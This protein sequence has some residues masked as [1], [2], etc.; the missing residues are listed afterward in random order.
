ME[1]E[2]LILKG[3][4][5]IEDEDKLLWDQLER[6]RE[7]I[8][9]SIKA[10]RV[11]HHLRS[12]GVI[13][14][15]DEEE[16]T[17]GDLTLKNE[18]MR[19]SRLLDILQTKGKKAYEVFMT[20]LETQYQ[21]VYTK[22]SGNP[23]KAGQEFP[24]P[25]PLLEQHHMAEPFPRCLIAQLV[26]LESQLSSKQRELGH[27]RGKI[28]ALEDRLKILEAKGVELVQVQDRLQRVQEERDNYS[29]ELARVKDENYT[30]AMRMMT[31]SNERTAAHM[32][33]RELQLEVDELKHVCN[34]A[35][36][37]CEV[38]R[39]NSRRV[40]KD[41]ER[42]PHA[43]VLLQLQQENALLRN[44][45]GKEKGNNSNVSCEH[46][47]EREELLNQIFSLRQELARAEE[48]RDKYLEDKGCLELKCDTTEKDCQ[49]HKHRIASILAE[50]QDVEKEREKALESRDHAQGEHARCL[51]IKDRQRKQLR[52]LQ[53][54]LD[55]LRV[56]FAQSQAQINSLNACAK[57][58]QAKHSASGTAN[59]L[60]P[61]SGRGMTSTG[62]EPN[63]SHPHVINKS[64]SLQDNI[65][66]LSL[67]F[68]DEVGLCKSL[69]ASA[70]K[71]AFM[72][73]HQYASREDVTNCK[74]K[75]DVH[76][77]AA[78][79]FPLEGSPTETAPNK[80]EN[81]K[82][83]TVDCQHQQ[84]RPPRL[85][86]GKYE[87]FNTPEN[88][89]VS[90]QHEE[91]DPTSTD[92]DT[93]ELLKFPDCRTDRPF[94]V[95]PLL[96]DLP[97]NPIRPVVYRT[98]LAKTLIN[99]VTVIG[100]NQTGVFLQTPH[101]GQAP[102]LTGLEENYQILTVEGQMRGPMERQRFLLEN[103]TK[104]EATWIL[105][106]LTAEVT[107]SL[108]HNPEG[109]A[110]VLSSP[111]IGDSFYVQIHFSLSPE[112]DNCALPVLCGDYLHITNSVP[113]PSDLPRCTKASHSLDG[114]SDFHWKNNESWHAW[115]IDPETLEHKQRG[116]VPNYQKAKALLLVKQKRLMG[117][118][119]DSAQQS[120][121]Q[122]FR[123]RRVEIVRFVRANRQG[124]WPSVRETNSGGWLPY[125]LVTP[126]RV[127]ARRPVV[128][129]P[130][131]VAR[132]LGPLLARQ[133][134]DMVHCLPV[135]L[136]PEE[137]AR[138]ENKGELLKSGGPGSGPHSCW[139][140]RSL[141]EQMDKVHC[142]IPIGLDA[143][144]LLHKADI[145][146]IIIFIFFKNK[147]ELSLMDPTDNSSPPTMAFNEDR[148][149]LAESGY[150]YVELKGRGSLLK[151]LTSEQDSG[152]PAAKDGTVVGVI[153][154][155]AREAVVTEQ[156][157]R[158]WVPRKHM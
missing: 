145:F 41:M 134:Q 120:W 53:E 133:H 111:D 65:S 11:T 135:N 78:S 62:S 37:E 14:V 52:E 86:Y 18:A 130:S 128:V 140:L 63:L 59:L 36:R 124:G 117:G 132:H 8:V 76:D 72:D 54:Q 151:A 93:R 112:T 80:T 105:Q 96:S 60:M 101:N 1:C 141:R 82:S 108:K 15:Q 27:L 16:V 142:V 38:V 91:E 24:D 146:P 69:P 66:N 34:E 40:L 149:A 129:L 102:G 139:L 92:R 35:K 9:N 25:L 100:G 21:N 6:F 5:D 157:R 113:S 22:I 87:A 19:M 136:S 106:N 123:S 144:E 131:L 97:Q 55:A 95:S 118:S 150:N 73:A 56:E 4:M 51:A 17:C 115:K 85:S 155:E 116:M 74:F 158:V 137:F 104:E 88:P 79:A 42:R 48:L 119:G 110:K 122:I 83:P 126:H 75:G 143:V 64:S 2:S 28:A 12:Y 114:D 138:R 84:F 156:K 154:Q 57:K 61:A 68:H 20:L 147:K 30:L 127:T 31:M 98:I 90:K 67:D 46:L 99:W 103:T 47:Q 70:L 13:S 94:R 7:V 77:T 152:A 33:C 23:P 39:R 153:L 50:L 10:S 26:R 109:F 121:S 44:R 3:S 71:A 32:R 125:T 58:L 89:R 49:M 43:E 29:D 107:L 45:V 148:K 81:D